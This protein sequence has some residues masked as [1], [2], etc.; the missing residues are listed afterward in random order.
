[1]EERWVGGGG[2]NKGTFEEATVRRGERERVNSDQYI[3]Q[4]N[5]F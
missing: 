2:K 1:M 4:I 5:L 3:K